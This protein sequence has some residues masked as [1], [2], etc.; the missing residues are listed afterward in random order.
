MSEKEVIL[1][2]KRLGSMPS[3]LEFYVIQ[4]TIGMLFILALLF[5]EVVNLIFPL[6]LIVLEI[7]HLTFVSTTASRFTKKKENWKKETAKPY[8]N[9]LPIESKE[10]VKIKIDMNETVERVHN[11]KYT[12]K[13]SVNRRS[14]SVSFVDNSLISLNGWYCVKVNLENGA[15]PYISYQKLSNKLGDGFESGYYNATIH[16]PKDYNFHYQ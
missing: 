11:E 13:M 1:S 12:Q 8:I 16:L 4:F 9:S 14:M 5:R 10:I 15:K 7:A 3:E 6:I 2:G